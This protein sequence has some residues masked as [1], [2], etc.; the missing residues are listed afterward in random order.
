MKMV[1]IAG[2]ARSGKDT[3][4]THLLYDYGFTPL[5]FA[6]PLKK[7]ISAMLNVNLE[8]IND[9]KEI[10][11]PVIG[12]SPRALLQT[13]GTEWGRRTL[14]TNTWVNI[15]HRQ[16]LELDPAT[17]GVVITDVRFE[18]EA[19]YIRG[20]GGIICH[21]TRPGITPVRAH[22]SE[23]GI[24]MDG[25]DYK[26]INDQDIYDVHKSVDTMMQL[27]PKLIKLRR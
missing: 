16:I 13:L 20:N 1:G 14:G 17:R 18:N 24:R 7:M 27:Y 21:V 10:E 6:A 12:Y 11:I 8:W 9:N 15:V 22:A 19:D 3:I 25:S 26:I 5:S 2:P 4:G 23:E